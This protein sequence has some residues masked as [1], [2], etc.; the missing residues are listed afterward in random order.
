MQNDTL[1]FAMR[2]LVDA[3]HIEMRSATGRYPIHSRTT[4]VATLRAVAESL[5]GTDPAHYRI[6][7][8]IFDLADAIEQE[9]QP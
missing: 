3:T 5:D 1:P 2:E 9:A 7:L 8:Y 4:I 6:K